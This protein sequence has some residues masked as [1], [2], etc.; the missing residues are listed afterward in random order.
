MIRKQG[1]TMYR[2]NSKGIYST[3]YWGVIKVKL[4]GE[5]FILLMDWIW[6]HEE[7]QN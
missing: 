2:D 7:F 3:L 6:G 4:H 1:L 5:V